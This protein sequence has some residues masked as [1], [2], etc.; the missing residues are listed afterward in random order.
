MLS[1][2]YFQY[3]IGEPYFQINKQNFCSHFFIDIDC[4]CYYN[5]SY[6]TFRIFFNSNS[7]R[8]CRTLC[9]YFYFDFCRTN[10]YS[11]HYE[12]TLFIPYKTTLSQK[13]QNSLYDNQL[14]NINYYFLYFD[15]VSN[16]SNISFLSL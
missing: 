2:C 9:F 3:Y 10:N 11:S 16:S 12:S 5:S 1:I 4:H 8:F 7:W 14:C 15:I 6:N 13:R